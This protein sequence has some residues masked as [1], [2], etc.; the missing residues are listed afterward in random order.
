M[1]GA[2]WAASVTVT[3]PLAVHQNLVVEESNGSAVRNC[4]EDWIDPS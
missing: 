1:I 2:V 4:M 3:L